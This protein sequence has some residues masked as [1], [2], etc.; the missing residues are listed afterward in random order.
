MTGAPEPKPS[1]LRLLAITEVKRGVQTSVLLKAGLLD[2]S[3]CISIL[4]DDRTLDLLLPSMEMRDKVFTALRSL[5]ED[6]ESVK[7]S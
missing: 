7:F 6:R 2:P 4:T 5:L 3:K 1:G